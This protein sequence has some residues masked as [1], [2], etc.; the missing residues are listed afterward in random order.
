MQKRTLVVCL[1]LS[2][3]FAGAGPKMNAQSGAVIPQ[4]GAGHAK[5]ASCVILKRM[6]PADEV[7]SHLYS[8]G[9]RGKQFQFV[10]GKLPDGFPFHGRLTDH[11]VRN[12]QGRGAEV[13]VIEPHYTAE[14]LKQARDEC[15]GMTGETPNQGAQ[16]APAAAV[17]PTPEKV[18]MPEPK[19]AAAP[20]SNNPEAS[21]TVE[22]TPPGADIEVDGAFVGNTPSTVTVAPGAHEIAVKKK[23]F[24]DWS[25]KL[26]VTGG[27]IHLNAELE[28]AKAQ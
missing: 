9:I 3:P 10:E 21:V 1:S 17:G 22:S 7:T 12:L 13:I 16:A 2:L 19:T 26:N 6:G 14:D 25:R 27:S 20:Q 5:S 18:S 4:G 8:F 11:D 24:A 15:K 28:A 23:G